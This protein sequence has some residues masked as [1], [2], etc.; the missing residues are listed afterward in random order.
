MYDA[1]GWGDLEAIKIDWTN[2]IKS[3]GGLNLLASS[4]YAKQNGLPVVSI[5]GLGYAS[6]PSSAAQALDLI[7]WFKAQGCYVVGSFPGQWR[8]GTNDSKLDL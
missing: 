2:T 4:A 7:N 5:Y 1:S 8:T 6:H 3:M